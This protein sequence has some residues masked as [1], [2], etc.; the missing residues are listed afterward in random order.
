VES[1][2]SLRCHAVVCPHR[3]G[4]LRDAEVADG[5]I[6]CPWHGYEFDLVTGACRQDRQLRLPK[7]PR[8]EVVTASGHA[9]LLH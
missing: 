7:P 9:W 6:R 8:V 2:G 5:R 4:P 3:L 1:G